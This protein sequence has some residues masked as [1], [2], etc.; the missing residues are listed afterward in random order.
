VRIAPALYK[1]LV[2][3]GEFFGNSPKNRTHPSAVSF[4]YLYESAVKAGWM[5]AVPDI[6]NRLRGF[7]F[8]LS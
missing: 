8:P 7:A 5:N 3:P 6:P 1:A 4:Q 2:T